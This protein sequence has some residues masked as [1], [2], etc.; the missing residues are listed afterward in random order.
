MIEK[1]KAEL[2]EASIH[3]YYIQSD[4]FKRPFEFKLFATY[5]SKGKAREAFEAAFTGL[6]V[7]EFVTP[8]NGMELMSCNDVFDESGKRMHRG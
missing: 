2:A 7:V 8:K 5:N 3:T 6:K 4:M 1:L